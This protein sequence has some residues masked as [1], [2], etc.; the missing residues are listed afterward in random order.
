MDKHFGCYDN[1]CEKKIQKNII[2]K[3]IDG[4]F[5]DG[6]EDNMHIMLIVLY[7]AQLIIMVV[8]V[9][10]SIGEKIKKNVG[11]TGKMQHLEDII[12]LCCIIP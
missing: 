11:Q 1:K 3:K 6:T 8:M 7:F 4:Y 2:C 12:F 10:N 5:H 9:T